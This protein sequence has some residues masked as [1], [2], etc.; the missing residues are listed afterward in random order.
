MATNGSRNTAA[1]SQALKVGAQMPV[2]G[3][4]ASPTPTAVPFKPPPP[5]DGADERHADERPHRE[6]QHPPCPRRQQLAPLLAQQ[7]AESNRRA[8]GDRRERIFLCGLCDRCG[9]F[10]T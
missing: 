2:S 7:P 3:E 5:A 6:Q 4:N 10:I 9:C 8:H 1:T